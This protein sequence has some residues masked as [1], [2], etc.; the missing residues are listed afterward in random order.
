VLESQHRLAA[1]DAVEGDR[2][3]LLS[4]G[5]FGSARTVVKVETR[6]IASIK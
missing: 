4:G 5:G 1:D 6:P 2:R 3:L